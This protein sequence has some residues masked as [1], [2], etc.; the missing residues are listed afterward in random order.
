M[1]FLSPELFL[2]DHIIAKTENIE[3]KLQSPTIATN[4]YNGV[5]GY[6]CFISYF[7]G[8]LRIFGSSV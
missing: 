2:D 1:L 4:K 6:Y 3:F 5:I 8:I 7:R